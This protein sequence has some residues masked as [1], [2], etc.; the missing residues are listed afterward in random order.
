MNELSERRRRVLRVAAWALL[1][2]GVGCMI[3]AEFFDGVTRPT[4]DGTWWEDLLLIVA[5]AAFPAMGTLVALRRPDNAIGWLLLGVGLQAGVLVLGAS[6]AR[7]ALVYREGAFPGATL[8]AW[9][10]AWGWLPL[11]LVIPTFLLL[12]FPTGRL[13]SRSWRPVA[14]LS[15]AL[16]VV[17]VVP[18]MVEERL[19]SDG[20]SIRNPIGISGLGDVE[21]G[22][23]NSLG[24]VLLLTLVLSAASLV[25]RYRRAATQ[26]RQQLKW[27]AL[28]GTALVVIAP[29]DD[30][31]TLPGFVFPLL[32]M[33][34]PVS[35][36]MAVLRYRLYDVD[37]IISRSVAYALLTS[38]LVGGYFLSVLILQSVLPLPERSPLIVAASTLLVVAAF[39]PL[40]AR[41]QRIVDRRFNRSRYDAALTIE[42][43]GQR[44]RQEVELEALTKD[45]MQV[46]DTTVRP[47]HLS[48]WIKSG[49][50]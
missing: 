50:N 47:A 8:G 43:F 24:P 44:L 15:G 16:L 13:P 11:I 10:E 28:A 34:I 20:Y 31:V 42:S 1:A 49:V 9:I 27:V 36:A 46:V 40:R 19:V 32:V 2:V 38:L 48:L 17:A 7:Y 33:G 25:A 35:I 23:F 26:E 30:W 4:P 12:L 3:A 22:L 41:I 45:L 18:S 29:L 37:R 14:W 5:F 39:G 6:Y 21:E